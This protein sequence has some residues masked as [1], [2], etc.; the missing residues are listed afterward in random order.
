MY[1]TE[2]WGRHDIVFCLDSVLPTLVESPALCAVGWHVCTGTEFTARNDDADPDYISLFAT[3]D[4]G[5][6]CIATTN[7]PGGPGHDLTSDDVRTD[8]PGTCTG[9]LNT[10]WGRQTST[11]YHGTAIGVAEPGAL[12]CF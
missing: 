11:G 1:G 4:D 2:L 5:D 3:L 6:A 10:T 8:A 12:C 9:T 7:N